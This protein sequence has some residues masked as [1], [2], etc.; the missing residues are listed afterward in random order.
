MPDIFTCYKSYNNFVKVVNGTGTDFY[1]NQ[2]KKFSGV[3]V[4]L[5]E[6]SKHFICIP[7]MNGTMLNFLCKKRDSGATVMGE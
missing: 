1:I 6:F 3:P 5:I 2:K 4:N 7:F